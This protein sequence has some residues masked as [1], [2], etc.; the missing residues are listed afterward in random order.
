MNRN[1][2]QFI[3]K[4]GGEN[5]HFP[6]KSLFEVY[7]DDIDGLIGSIE[8]VIS[9]YEPEAKNNGSWTGIRSRFI[10]IIRD[11]RMFL[12]DIEGVS[13][14]TEQIMAE[15]SFS[16]MGIN[17]T[18][19]FIPGPIIKQT[20]FSELGISVRESENDVVLNF[21]TAWQRA[22]AIEGLINFSLRANI[23]I[24]EYSKNGE[25]RNQHKFYKASPI[26]ISGGKMVMDNTG[27]IVTRD[28]AFIF[29]QYVP[30]TNL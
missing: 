2:A 8:N 10:E 30:K 27:D 17:N 5:T 21:F 23:T 12:D 3:D 9:Q 22:V 7:I 4:I 14:P 20:Q 11:G 24:N 26:N 29:S 18:G 28:V 25:V 1:A 13:T 19:G 15:K 16:G 6:I